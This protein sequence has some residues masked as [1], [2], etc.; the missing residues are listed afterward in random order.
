MKFLNLLKREL[1]LCSIVTA[2][3]ALCALAWGSPFV[4]HSA[5]DGT[6]HAQS[7][8]QS[9]VFTGR[10]LR[11]GG[12]YLLRDSSGQVF[13]LDDPDHAGSYEGRV[14]TITGSIDAASR[15]IHIERIGASS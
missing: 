13:R 11:N 4:G 9:M 2:S 6:A 8:Q 12:Q 15:L 5:G 14:V 7:L 1:F 3:V 10:V